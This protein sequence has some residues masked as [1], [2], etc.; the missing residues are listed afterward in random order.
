MAKKG[1]YKIPFDKKGTLLD[2]IANDGMYY[3]DTGTRVPA[4]MEDNVVFSD[5][6]EYVDY[7][8][9]RSSA[10]MHFK[11]LSSN[12]KFHMTLKDFHEVLSKKKMINNKIVGDFTFAKRGANF[13]LV[14]VFPEN[15]SAP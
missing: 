7:S 10:H 14:P 13:M 1:N 12:R 3:D 11:S 8:Q 6:L 15:Q 2:W 4:I 5:T 9:G